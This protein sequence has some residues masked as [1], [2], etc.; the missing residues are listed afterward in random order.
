MQFAQQH[1]EDRD[2]AA[3][4]ALC[5]SKLCEPVAA[6]ARHAAAATS[7][8]ACKAPLPYPNLAL[9]MGIAYCIVLLLRSL[10]LLNSLRR[11]YR[12]GRRAGDRLRWWN[13]LLHSYVKHTYMWNATVTFRIKDR[14][15][16]A[17][18]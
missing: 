6:L 14:P 2:S 4:A 7:F 1:L 12:L 16:A 17:A 10:A 15:I 5:V 9:G 3:A 18:L 11:C 13:R 8:A